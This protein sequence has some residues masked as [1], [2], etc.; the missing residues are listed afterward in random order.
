L[1]QKEGRA[2][3]EIKTRLACEKQANKSDYSL[4]LSRKGRNNAA[5]CKTNF[6]KRPPFIQSIFKK[7]IDTMKKEKNG[8]KKKA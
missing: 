6:I 5:K 2:A 3:P 4:S 1:V 8:H 7:V